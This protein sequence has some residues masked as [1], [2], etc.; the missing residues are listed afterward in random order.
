MTSKYLPN[1]LFRSAEGKLC[2]WYLSARTKHL[3]FCLIFFSSNSSAAAIVWIERPKLKNIWIL[4]FKSITCFEIERAHENFWQ[5]SRKQHASQ[6]ECN[7]LIKR[8]FSISTFRCWWKF[9]FHWDKIPK[10]QI[11]R[12]KKFNLA[13]VFWM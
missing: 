3:A 13:Y 11:C 5:K 9:F 6:N 2:C 7:P 1:K 10:N 4:K 8:D 12:F